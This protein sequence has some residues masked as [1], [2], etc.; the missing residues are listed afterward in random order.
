MTWE[1]AVLDV[2]K[3]YTGS[4]SQMRVLQNRKEEPIITDDEYFLV[5]FLL[6]VIRKRPVPIDTIQ[7]VEAAFFVHRK[8]LTT[9]NLDGRRRVLENNCPDL[10]NAVEG[11]GFFRHTKNG[12]YAIHYPNRD[13]IGQIV[14][15]LKQSQVRTKKSK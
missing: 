15:L 3:R 1:E 10:K 8:D 14:A 9:N 13:Y 7:S 4:P 6:C 11:K 12:H 5:A 2:V